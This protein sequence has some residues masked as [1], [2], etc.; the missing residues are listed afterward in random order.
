MKN[1]IVG[2]AGHVDHGKT[3]LI[4][5][6]TGTDTDR[7]KEEKK[8]G[9]TIENGF[10]DMQCGD[11]NISIIDVP[12]HERFIKNM[13][14][15]IGG[16]DLVLLVVG[17]DEGVMP[18][19]AEHL[20]ILDM[21]N[22]RKGIIVFTK[23]DLVDDEEWAELVKDDAMS[24]VEGTFLEGA[25]SIEVSAFD[26][27]HIEELKQLIVE[28]IDEETLRD[29]SP[30][31]FRLPVDRVFTI[32]G[33]GTVITG[34]LIE[35]SVST[36]DELQVY[37]SG[38]LTR[39]RNVQVHNEAVE[40]AYAGQ[41]TAINLGGLKK[42][43]VQRGEVLARKG[44]LEPSMMLDVRLELFKDMDRQV[45][46]GSRVHVYCGS[47]EVLGKVVLLDRETAEKGEN[48]YAQ[49]RLE[50]N[51]A[52]KRGDRFIIRF[53]SPVITIGGGKVL[54]ACPKK[55]KRYDET[56]LSAMK[57]KDEGSLEEVILLM[58]RENSDAL[59]TGNRLA[60]RLR[61]SEQQMEQFLAPLLEDGRLRLIR[62]EFI[63]H[64][65]Y[66]QEVY[67]RGETILSAYHQANALSA[68]MTREEF[69]SRL[70]KELRLADGRVVEDIIRTMEEAGRIRLGEK[71]VCLRDFQV[72]YTPEMAAMRERI[73]QLYKQ[74]RFEFPS[75][76]E[77]LDTETDKA[78]AGHIVEALSGEGKLVRLDYRYYIDRDAFDW[79]LD[80]LKQK[81]A[82]NGQITLAEFRDIIGTSRKYAMEILEYLDREK[83][84]KKVD[85]ARI[86]L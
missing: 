19:T 18:Q 61:L 46:N 20:Q 7:L 78:N 8:R 28:N 63:M 36:G 15:G 77:V 83:I 11:Y 53:Y 57:I 64:Q 43:D 30:E 66:L 34:T 21:L 26:G 24:L 55:H 23:K 16:I 48:C 33:F 22:I 17:L 71:T 74:K 4:K 86:L 29:D 9:I 51:I 41:R 32:G 42:E 54:D 39:A 70:G 38:S 35:G 59:L 67:S 5:A 6:L 81:V 73:L 12:G 37:P 60:S 10:A 68:G 27:Y 75:L 44:S 69:K 14:A 25:P 79:A 62:K 1:I 72:S 45:R 13:L 65:D 3:C 56:V 80:E 85:D 47:S 40:T 52:V 31:L 50:E 58:A 49:L 2:T 82:Q 84:T 76:D